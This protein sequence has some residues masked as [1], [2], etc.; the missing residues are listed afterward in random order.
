MAKVA[1]RQSSITGYGLMKRMMRRPQYRF[2]LIVR[3]WQIQPYMVAPVLPGETMKNL[4]LQARTVSKPIKNA[5]IGWWAE[6][7]IFYVKFRD[8][9]YYAGSEVWQSMFLDPEADMSSKDSAAA[10]PHYHANANMPN[11]SLECLKPV[12]ERYFRDEGEAW[13]V[14]LIDTLPV[15]SINQDSFLD[16]LQADATHDATDLPV[17]LDASGTVAT[18]MASEVQKALQLYNLLN[19]G[20]LSA[21]TFEDFLT[22]YGIK[23]PREASHKPELLRYVRQWTYPSNTVEPTTGIPSSAVSWSIQERADKD[24]LFKEPG[25]IF[26]VQVIRPKVYLNRLKGSA[27]DIM[28]DAMSWLPAVLNDDPTTSLVNVPDNTILGDNTDAG[29]AWIDVKDLF[30][31]GDQYVNYA[32]A[33]AT[34][35]VALP[36]VAYQHRYASSADADALFSAASPANTIATDGVVSLSIATRLQDTSPKTVDVA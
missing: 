31:Y 32:F 25:F 15:A 7:Y 24:R 29:G 34:S 19:V 10:V 36:T 20:D 3:P 22:T 30:M 4:L 26:A 33:G 28:S 14:N 23:P 1:I 17:D 13:N 12:V 18:I 5:L 2:N 21:M 35:E 11:Y 9:D 16:S 27:V 8:L 6:H